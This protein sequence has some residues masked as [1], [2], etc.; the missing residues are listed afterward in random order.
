MQMWRKADFFLGTMS[1]MS[2]WSHWW[3]IA[4]AYFTTNGTFSAADETGVMDGASD[5]KENFAF[6]RKLTLEQRMLHAHNCTARMGNA[7][8]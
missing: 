5:N 7:F 8:R 4:D 3:R 2:F 6:D 1:T